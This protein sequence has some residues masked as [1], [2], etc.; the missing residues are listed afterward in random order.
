MD[1]ESLSG[2]ARIGLYRMKAR[3]SGDRAFG[4]FGRGAVRKLNAG[5][6]KCGEDVL[7]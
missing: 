6:V 7:A 1:G 2:S 4:L 3:S 5:K